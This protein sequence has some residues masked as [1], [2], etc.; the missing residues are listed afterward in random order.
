MSWSR[1]RA[2]SSAL[3][4]VP[5]AAR[6]MQR[7]SR[8][9]TSR[10]AITGQQELPVGT[11]HKLQARAMSSLSDA[12]AHAP[13]AE[14]SADEVPKGPKISKVLKHVRRKPIDVSGKGENTPNLYLKFKDGLDVAVPKMWLRDACP[15]E[16]CVDPSSGQKTFATPDV[17]PRPTVDSSS[18][19][20]SGDL[21]VTWASDFRDGQ[22]HESLYSKNFIDAYLLNAKPSP[23]HGLPNR[24]IW[25][26]SKL[27]Q[28]ATPISH[29]DWMSGGE[30]FAHAFFDL[31]RYGIIFLRD[32]PKVE[33]AVEDVA[34]QIGNLQSTFYG[35]T[36]D[37]KSKPQAENVAYTDVFLGLHQDLMYWMDVP[38]I[39]IL[40]CLENSCEGGDSIISDGLRAAQKIRVENPDHFT[41]LNTLPVAYHYDIAPHKYT[42]N[43]TVINSSKMGTIADIFWSPPFQAPFFLMDKDVSLAKRYYEG[44]NNR[45]RWH[46]AAKSFKASIEAPENVFQYKMKPGDC[47]L[48]DNR[49]VLH[50]RRAFDTSSGKRWLKGGYVSSEVL[51][52]RGLALLEEGYKP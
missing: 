23:L 19:T 32:V 12:T 6:L 49:R 13:Q 43:R 29:S 2:T 20:A 24:Q 7:P 48:F 4:E 17:P 15:C 5:N 3:R 51:K 36:W 47:V 22:R 40:H 25:D 14:G 28:H 37:V 27:E 39:Q 26:R 30:A 31:I 45:E 42:R 41:A 1:L 9:A 10:H 52:S 34:K 16:T 21:Q 46:A 33:W 35:M 11:I 18:I 50:G 44:K 38:K 8:H